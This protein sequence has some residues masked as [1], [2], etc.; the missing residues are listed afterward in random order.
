M[1]KKAPKKAAAK[2]AAA[3]PA[4]KPA[5]PRDN[6]DLLESVD[7]MLTTEIGRTRATI[8]R[9]MEWG[10]QSLV[11]LDKTVDQPVDI[12]L[13]GKLFARGE[14]VTVGENF[15]VRVVEVVEPAD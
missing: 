5:P 3:A 4:A 11:E 12:L 9:V 6:I 8:E 15:G 13:N 14:V 2:K 7:L 10:E 1:A